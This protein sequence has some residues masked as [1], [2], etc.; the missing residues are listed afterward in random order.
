MEK[1]S[2]R[3]IYSVIVQLVVHAESISWDR[4]YNFL[5]ANSILILS[6]A[7][8]FSSIKNSWSVTVVLLAI[9][10]L[11]AVS[12]ICFEKLGIRGRGF[13][14]RYIAL[15]SQIEADSTNWPPELEGNKPLTETMNLRDNR[16]PYRWSGSRYVLRFGPL[17]FTILYIVLFVVS[18]IRQC[19]N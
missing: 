9:C 12:G 18:L 1:I 8:I 4:F 6:W 11:G 14:D 17:S 5:I 16:L 13:L 10:L 15:G 7:T 19:G 3:E 2:A